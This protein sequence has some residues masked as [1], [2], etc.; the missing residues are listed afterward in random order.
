[1]R[2]L[3]VVLLLAANQAIAQGASYLGL[4]NPSWPCKATLATWP[5]G[6]L[7]VTGWLEETFGRNCRCS[8][9]ILEAPNPKIIRVHL[10]NNTC[11]RNGRRCH[12]GEFM[13]GYTARR[14]SKRLEARN[15]RVIARFK[16]TVSRFS[17]RM[18]KAVNVVRCYVSPCLECT[19]SS[20]ARGVLR[21]LASST[22]CVAVDNIISGHC[23]PGT[24]C[25][26]HGFSPPVRTPCIVDLDGVDGRTID[27]AK[28]GAI[29]RECLLYYWERWMNCLNEP[30]GKSDMFI[31]PRQRDCRHPV[32]KFKQV[33]KI[34]QSL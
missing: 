14:M 26:K 25:E 13:F 17:K 5:N 18:E 11:I 31:D 23:L 6:E 4:C 10:T 2:A 28:F 27:V 12:E 33:R 15:K 21:D 16:R 1:M 19:L 9:A 22:G 8:T 20:G 29:N 24:V 34:C 30:V 3:L 32:S 7:I